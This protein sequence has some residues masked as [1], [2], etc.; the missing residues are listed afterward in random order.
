MRLIRELKES[1]ALGVRVA[2]KAGSSLMR[3]RWLEDVFI[4]CGKLL[5]WDR[6]RIMSRAGRAAPGGVMRALRE[7]S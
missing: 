6:P 7:T 4:S 1:I 2:A 3:E 5:P